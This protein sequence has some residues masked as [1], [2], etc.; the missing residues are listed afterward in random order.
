MATTGFFDPFG[1]S[2][3]GG[4]GGPTTADKVSYNNTESG[5]QSDNVQSAI[6]KLVEL[7][8]L[9]NSK[10]LKVETIGYGLFPELW[11]NNEYHIQSEHII[12]TNYICLDMARQITEEE[13]DA[14][15]A[16]KI[17]NTE[18]TNGEIVIKALGEVPQITIPIAIT[19]F[20]QRPISDCIIW[21]SVTNIPYQIEVRD[22][23]VILTEVELDDIL[24]DIKQK[25]LII[26]EI[27]GQEYELTIEQRNV[28]LKEV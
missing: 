14:L 15:A 22:R 11:E 3:G 10:L 8:K 1:S 25:Y 26:D 16:A 23:D 21:D 24:P 19:F 6:D 12:A 9:Q 18:Q 20:L 4:G 27:T 5:L 28:L 2:G 17:I 7:I 13:Y